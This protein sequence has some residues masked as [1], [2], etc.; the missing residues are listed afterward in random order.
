MPKAQGSLEYMVIIAVV[1]AIAGITVLYMS[2]VLSSQSSQVSATAC[3]QASQACKLSQMSSPNDPCLSCA[4][5]C[6]SQTTGREV[7]NGA[8]YCCNHTLEDFIYPGSPGCGGG[9]SY[10]PRAD[11]Y[12]DSFSNFNGWTGQLFSSCTNTGGWCINTG[13][14][15]TGAY[16]DSHGAYAITRAQSTVKYKDIQLSFY[17]QSCGDA[18]G[19]GISREFLKV[20]W[21]ADGGTTWTTLLDMNRVTPWTLKSYTLPASAD[22]NL[23]FAVR[24]TAYDSHDITSHIY[25]TYAYPYKDLSQIDDFRITGIPKL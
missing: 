22:E 11:V 24:I 18:G 2:G 14:T 8:T 20:D 12:F 16:M 9:Y 5:A 19:G 6:I 13:Y 1:L 23:N 10:G 17:T 15:S 25:C 4:T 21:T 3:R 7:F